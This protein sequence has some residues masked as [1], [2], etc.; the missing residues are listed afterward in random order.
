M[1]ITQTRSK[2]KVTGGIYLDYRKKRKY[3]LGREPRE[4]KVAPVRKKKFDCLGGNVKIGLLSAD[5]ANVFDGKKYSK[6]KIKQVLENKANRHFV[7]RNIIN[8]GAVI[9][10]EIGKARVTSR[11]GQEGGINAVLIKA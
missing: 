5:V 2:R 9:E 1:A 4:T 11:P 10:T 8:K 7:R 3:E 6:V